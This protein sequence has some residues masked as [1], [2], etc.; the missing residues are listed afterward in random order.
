MGLSRKKRR[1]KLSI[2]IQ[3]PTCCSSHFLG[4]LAFATVQ[5]ILQRTLC[6]GLPQVREPKNV[7]E[8]RTMMLR[9]DSQNPAKT[10]HA[11]GLFWAQ[12]GG[13]SWAELSWGC[14]WMDRWITLD[15]LQQLDHL[16]SFGSLKAPA[17]LPQL[18]NRWERVW[19]RHIVC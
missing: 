13:L 19:G 2:F 1:F 7:P 15:N 4:S 18:A 11:L 9:L 17:V 3:I 16:D 12:W 6:R 10:P 8:L 5:T 14:S